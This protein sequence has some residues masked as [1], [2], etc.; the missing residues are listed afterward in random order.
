MNTPTPTARIVTMTPEWAERLLTAN[1]TNRDLRQFRVN[2]LAADMVAGSFLLNGATVV[3]TSDGRLL[4]GQHR[5]EAC[6][7]T[8]TPF[9]VV[10]VEGIDPAAQRTMDTGSPRSFADVLKMERN[11]AN[12]ASLGAATSSTW[13]FQMNRGLWN[14]QY[15]AEKRNATRTELLDWHDEHEE[16]LAAV[17]RQARQIQTSAARL[18]VHP[19]SPTLFAANLLGSEIA[20]EFAELVASGSGELDNATRQLREYGIRRSQ[21]PSKAPAGTVHLVTVRAWNRWVAGEPAHKLT[22]KNKA[23]DTTRISILDQDGTVLFPFPAAS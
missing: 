11:K 16:I 1:A 9:E 4:D 2:R 3:A 6:R 19:I 14:T 18:P 12:A 20:D 5:L 10:L 22:S 13:Y 17:D 21:S 23:G 7:Q 15:L 8:G